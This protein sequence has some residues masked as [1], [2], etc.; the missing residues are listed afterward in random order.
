MTAASVQLEVDGRTVRLTN[1]TQVLWP[2]APFT[3]GQ[4]IDY[5]ARIAPALLPHLAR[6]PLTLTRFPDGID[7]PG[8]Y[9]TTCPHPPPWVETLPVPSPTPG[10]EG[11]NY[12]LVDNL[13]GLLWVAN[14][15]A[16]ELHPLLSCAPDL[17]RPTAVIFDLDPGPPAGPLEVAAVALLVRRAL[18]AFSLRSVVKTSGS[19]GIHV[20][21]PLNTPVTYDE[22]RA[23]ARAVADVLARRHPDLVVARMPR[24]LRGGRVLVDWNQN[25]VNKSTAGVYSLRALSFPAVSTPLRWD[26]IEAAV[27]RGD[28]NALVFDALGV[29]ARIEAVGDLF[30]PALHERQTLPE[31]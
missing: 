30:A 17:D 22:T 2:H 1:L 23:F 5:Y 24:A 21:V 28:E 7:G 14:L 16:V 6:R 20:L 29:L 4:M 31:L 3:K 19:M 15:G 13:A 10:K 27:A 11:R 8:W 9:Q 26:E 25:H 18:E 12:C